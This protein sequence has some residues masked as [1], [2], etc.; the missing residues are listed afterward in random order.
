MK[1]VL[2]CFLKWDKPVL[3]VFYKFAER[4]VFNIQAFKSYQ[5]VV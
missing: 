4:K 3:Y 1:Y 2:K 5:T